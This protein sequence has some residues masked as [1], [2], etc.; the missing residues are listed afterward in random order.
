MSNVWDLIV[1]GNF[2]EACHAADRE[3]GES[4]SILP[5]RNKVFALLCLW[6]HQDAVD[7]CEEIIRRQQGDTDS[8]FIF[9]G[10]SLWLLRQ[11]KKAITTWESAS[12]TVYTDAAGGIE[13]P[14]L[15]FYAGVRCEDPLLREQAD[16]QLRKLGK[17]KAA[18]NWPGPIAHFVLNELSEQQLL[19]KTSKQPLVRAKQRCQAAFFRG[20]VRLLNDDQ[21]GFLACMQE[22]VTQGPTSLMQQEYYLANGELQSAAWP[23]P[24]EMEPPLGR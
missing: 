14:L 17:R 3:A 2:E 4:L 16:R 1:A 23:G 11:L 12:Q 24:N 21:G 6:R 8:D 5:L 22:S 10:V 7:I 18:G 13:V 19:E 15:L 20:V 9:L